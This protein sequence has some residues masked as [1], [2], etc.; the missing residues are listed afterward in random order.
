MRDPLY[1]GWRIYLCGGCA[2][3]ASTRDP[4]G[5]SAAFAV[6]CGRSTFLGPLPPPSNPNQGPVEL[7]LTGWPRH[8]HGQLRPNGSRRSATRGGK[9]QAHRPVN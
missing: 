9:E 2:G 1:D 5:I 6:Q 8:G 3:P 7:A 4:S